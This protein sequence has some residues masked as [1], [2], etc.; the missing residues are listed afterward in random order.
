MR[1]KAMLPIIFVMPLVQM[2]ILV[3]AATME[4]KQVELY[5]VDRDLTETSR[6]LTA[7]FEASPF[8]EVTRSLQ[9]PA[10]IDRELLKGHAD[11]VLTIPQGFETSLMRED[12]SSLQILVDA[13]YELLEVQPVDMFPH[14]HHIECVA[15]LRRALP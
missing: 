1:N 10:E 12:N 13:G 3:F 5:V 6:K 14:T 4:L 8:F 2:L 11:V 15:T 7:K 9:S